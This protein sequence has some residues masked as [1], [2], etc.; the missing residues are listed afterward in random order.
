V[1]HKVPKKLNSQFTAPVNIP[2]NVGQNE[3]YSQF[4]APVNIPPNV[5]QNENY[6]VYVLCVTGRAKMM[7]KNTVLRDNV[8]NKIS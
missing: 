7:Q 5:E 1:S 3:N 4:T 8:Q 6:I 2:Q